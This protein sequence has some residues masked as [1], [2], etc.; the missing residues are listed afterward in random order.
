MIVSNDKLLLKIEEWNDKVSKDNSISDI[1]L[2]K[3]FIEFEKFLTNSFISYTLG[4][5]GNNSFSPKLRLI[6]DDKEHLEGLLKCNKAYI[7]Y[8]EKI[9][10]VR[11]FIFDDSSCPFNKVF[12][13]AEFE[14]LFKQI[15]ILRNFIAHESEESKE[16]YKK[17]VLRANGISTYREVHTFLMD[18]N[19]KKN[20]PYYTIYINFF[21]FYSEIICDPRSN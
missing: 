3:I 20:I 18:I 14:T 21:K 12:S 16:K 4:K 11:K 17:N 2:L 10:E 8:I 13:T 19:K 5:K 15:K 1:A 9:Q 6:F 7:E